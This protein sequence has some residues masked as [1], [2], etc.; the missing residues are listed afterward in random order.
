VRYVIH[1]NVPKSLDGYYQETG[2]AGRD[3]KPADCIMCEYG[4]F[5]GRTPRLTSFF[6][7]WNQG[8]RNSLC[9]MIDKNKEVPF[10]ERKRQKDEVNEVIAYCEDTVTCRRVQVL[11]HFGQHFD[12]ADCHKHCDN[13]MDDT[14]AVTVD[15]T[16]LARKA[17]QLATSLLKSQK[18]VTKVYLCDVLRGAKTKTVIDNGHDKE[19][20]HGAGKDDKNRL[21]RLL[22][23]LETIQALKNKVVHN[24]GGFSNSY[25]TVRY[26]YWDLPCQLTALFE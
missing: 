17:I 12:R 8:D 11:K 16:D 18:N 20:F 21:E 19:E 3:G 10:E 15:M 26:S 25:L 13:C 5:Q 23:E 1:V 24:K 4:L 9:S 7:D 22:S 14:P 6:L 2:R